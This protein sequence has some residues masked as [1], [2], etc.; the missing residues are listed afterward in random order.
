LF[1]IPKVAE[2][3]CLKT[4]DSLENIRIIS[5]MASNSFSPTFSPK[6]AS[7]STFAYSQL[8]AEIQAKHDGYKGTA[9]LTWV[10]VTPYIT[11]F[12]ISLSTERDIDQMLAEGWK[13]INGNA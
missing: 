7:M 2:N 12:N 4:I 6:E 9:F 3:W 11:R 13:V 5:N 1:R 8:P 10:K